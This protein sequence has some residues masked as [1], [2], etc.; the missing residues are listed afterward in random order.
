MNFK[1]LTELAFYYV[2]LRYF[3]PHNTR[4]VKCYF[5]YDNFNDW[6]T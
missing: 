5:F 4:N 1:I 3:L 2:L 6:N